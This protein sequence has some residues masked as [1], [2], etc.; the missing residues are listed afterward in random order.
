MHDLLGV[1]G[2]ERRQ[3]LVHQREHLARFERTAQAHAALL[4]GLPLEQLHHQECDA[5]FGDTVVV[6]RDRAT[7]ADLIGRIALTQEALLRVV[8]GR[9]LR[10]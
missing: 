4:D 2:L 9:D 6:R 7:M 10:M 3:R 1:R 8:V 5:V